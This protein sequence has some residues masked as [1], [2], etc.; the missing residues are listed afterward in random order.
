M[1]GPMSVVSLGTRNL[2]IFRPSPDFS[3]GVQEKLHMVD[4]VTHAP[5]RGAHGL[6]QSGRC[7]SGEAVA[8]TADGVIELVTPA[9]HRTVDTVTILEDLR[10]ELVGSGAGLLGAGLHPAGAF[11]DIEDHDR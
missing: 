1:R 7:A 6:P 10:R 2:P 5:C 9:C 4:P 11:V 8:D 3:L